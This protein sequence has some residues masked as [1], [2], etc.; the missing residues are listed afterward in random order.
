MVGSVARSKLVSF[1]FDG[2]DYTVLYKDDPFEGGFYFF[3]SSYLNFKY[4]NSMIVG[5]R[6]ENETRQLLRLDYAPSLEVTLLKN[7]TGGEL[8]LVYSCKAFYHGTYMLF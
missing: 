8:P 6:Y 1:D 7:F 4:R 2:G 5:D 3:R